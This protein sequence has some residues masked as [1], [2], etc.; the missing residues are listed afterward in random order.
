[1]SKL[2][3]VPMRQC[4][5]CFQGDGE[6]HTSFARGVVHFVH[7]VSRSLHSLGYT[8]FSFR[9]PFFPNARSACL[10]EYTQCTSSRL[11]V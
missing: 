10:T 1:M 8:I 3:N 6:S 7:S 5:N 11:N 4:A 2:V 9:L